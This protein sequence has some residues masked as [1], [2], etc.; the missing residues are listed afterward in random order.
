MSG[1]VRADG[2]AV[3]Y[4]GDDDRPIEFRRNTGWGPR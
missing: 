4:T 3:E 2:A 1:L